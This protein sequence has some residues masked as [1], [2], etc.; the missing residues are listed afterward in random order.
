MTFCCL[1]EIIVL[2]YFLPVA[3]RMEFP[4]RHKMQLRVSPI[5]SPSAT[6][7]RNKLASTE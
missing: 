3:S 1:E 4:D 7:H 6:A 5:E 2:F